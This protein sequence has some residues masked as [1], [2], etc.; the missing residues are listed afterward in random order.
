VLEVQF[1]RFLI[2][3]LDGD[4]QLHDPAALPSGKNGGSR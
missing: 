4:G 1:H 2:S 3:A